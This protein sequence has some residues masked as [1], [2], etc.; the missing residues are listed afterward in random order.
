MQT[1][2]SINNNNI[3]ID[4]NALNKNILKIRYLNSRKLSNNLLKHDYKISKNMKESIKFSKNVHKLSQNEKNVYY[5]LKKY[6]N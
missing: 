2:Q 6:M 4:E 3:K 5:E 1:G